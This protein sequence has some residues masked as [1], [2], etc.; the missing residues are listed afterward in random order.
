VIKA[1][2]EPAAEAFIR[3]LHSSCPSTLLFKT[4]KVENGAWKYFYSKDLDSNFSSLYV[5]YK[6]QDDFF[7]KCNGRVFLKKRLLLIFI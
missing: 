7:E 6:N 1:L 3:G 5:V 2:D 4:Q